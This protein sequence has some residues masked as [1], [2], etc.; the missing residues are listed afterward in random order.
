MLIDKQKLIGVLEIAHNASFRGAGLSLIDALARS[1]YETLRKEFGP[2]DLVPHLRANPRLVKDWVMYCQDKRTSG[3]FWLSEDS[4]AVG[5]GDS[6]VPAARYASLEEAVAN[7]IIR[8]LDL[9]SRI[10]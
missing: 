3:G 2:S 10:R 6:P 5:A 7:F 9:A 1:D 8:E 4:F